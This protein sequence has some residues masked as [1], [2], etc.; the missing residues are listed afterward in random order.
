MAAE[1]EDIPSQKIQKI[2]SLTKIPRY[3]NFVAVP[4]RK[5]SNF[6]SKHELH[7]DQIT[8]D[9]LC[10]K[11]GLVID[12]H[13]VISQNYGNWSSN[14]D[15]FSTNQQKNRNFSQDLIR[16][17]K[18]GHNISWNER[19]ELIGINEINRIT[20]LHNIGKSI[21]ERAIK[22][23]Q[24]IIR[25]DEFQ[26][27]Y[28]KLVAAVSIF[29]IIKEEKNPLCLTEI[30]ENT[31]FSNRLANKY[32][33]V[34]RKLLNIRTLSG[35]SNDPNIYV[36]KIC[37]LLRVDQDVNELARKIIKNF[38]K[39]VN[40]SG[41]KL[42]GIAAAGVYIACRLNH[43]PKSQKEVSSAADITDCT[44]RSRVKNMEIYLRRNRSIWE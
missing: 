2:V 23:F 21:K 6:C 38:K 16:A 44:L 12:E 20:A 26:N 8:G 36:P 7:I 32:Y 15:K 34:L 13:L 1:I 17:L 4:K 29:Q 19:R 5:I 30:I 11:C 3:K 33:Y 35:E 10:K 28:I 14:K 41:F 39:S 43:I 18:R 37:S 42:K 31:G 25:E 27:H 24:K 40:C 9:T 22:L